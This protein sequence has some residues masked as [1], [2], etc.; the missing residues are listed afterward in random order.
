MSLSD[1]LHEALASVPGTQIAGVIGT[2]GLRIEVV[3]AD[4]DAGYDLELAELELA[5]L[6]AAA[7]AASQRV[8]SGYVLLLSLESEDLTYLAGLI[9][10]GYFA[11]LVLFA[12]SDI[13]QAHACLE[14][15]VERMRSEL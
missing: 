15:L 3:F 13:G 11:L 14:R 8:G 2:D 12:D 6:T 9:T 4:D 10:P 7:T 5:T 1:I